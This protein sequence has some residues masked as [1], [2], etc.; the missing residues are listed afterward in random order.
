MSF[1]KL[2]CERA[3]RNLFNG[4]QRYNDYALL[5]DL[6]KNYFIN[7]SKKIEYAIYGQHDELL[8]IGNSNECCD[9]LSVTKQTFYNALYKTRHKEMKY[10]KYKVYRMESEVQEDDC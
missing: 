10:R 8:F 3:L 7:K 5:Q 2:E 6:I 4:N 9:F 1:D